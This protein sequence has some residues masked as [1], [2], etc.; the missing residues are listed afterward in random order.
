MKRAVL[1]FMTIVL[2]VWAAGGLA[3][4]GFGFVDTF[5]AVSTG[6]FVGTRIAAYPGS[7]D[8]ILCGYYSGKTLFG[9]V[10][11]DS[12][13]GASQGVLMRI[14][15]RGEVR[16]VCEIT[17]NG[18]QRAHDLA[19][20]PAGDIYVTGRSTGAAEIEG[21]TQ[22]S[23]S[24]PYSGTFMFLAKYDPA[25]NLVWVRN[26]TSTGQVSGKGVTVDASG[27]VYVAGWFLGDASF[28][29]E[30]VFGGQG[31]F[32]GFVA[33]YDS[34]GEKEWVKSISTT[35]RSGSYEINGVATDGAGSI[36]LTG[37]FMGS[38]SVGAFQLSASGDTDAFLARCNSAGEIQWARK[39]GGEG[40]DAAYGL[41]ADPSG[42]VVVVGRT[43]SPTA[44]FGDREVA[45]AGEG[46]G[47][48]AG[49]DSDGD[50]SWAAGF[51][52]PGEDAA[53]GV[54]IKS[55]GRIAV[56]GELSDTVMI[57]G[58]RFESRGG[59]DVFVALYSPSGDFI[60]GKTGGG[61]QDDE[62]R[63]AAWRGETLAVAGGFKDSAVFGDRNVG[64]NADLGE[65]FVSIMGD[66]LPSGALAGDF[67]GDGQVNLGDAIGVLR[68]LT[69]GDVSEEAIAADMDG[70]G[71]VGM[72]DAIA[73]LQYLAFQR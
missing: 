65:L 61:E 71:R 48:V 68:M 9:G 51:G 50:I 17:G 23:V 54:S 30:T 47:F 20:S 44:A 41:T 32:D 70:D 66:I 15:P 53:R 57:D 39:A 14:G 29:G 38:V 45:G 73:I 34:S 42:G 60:S 12:E 35:T 18:D 11:M 24:L 28:E 40:P 37:E 13:G 58:R 52:G 56:I 27:D 10:S 72:E 31:L 22:E 64:T 25:G 21:G 33:K 69:F 7:D 36:F 43:S 8:M 46:D 5:H 16:W 62:G 63:T 49:Y 2:P 67:T 6:N 3:Y 1:L 4:A 55:S 59:E 19:L 26:G